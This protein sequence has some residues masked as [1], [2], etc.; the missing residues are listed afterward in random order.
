MQ[1]DLRDEYR[2]LN[3]DKFLP[4]PARVLFNVQLSTNTDET[5]LKDTIRKY[6]IMS[7]Y[8]LG[9]TEVF[10]SKDLGIVS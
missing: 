8:S 2:G 10:A 6:L 1:S 3:I 5:R 9:G 4:D 7:N